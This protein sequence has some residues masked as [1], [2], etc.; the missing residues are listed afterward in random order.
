M[1]PCSCVEAQRKAAGAPA[2]A[3]ALASPG[4]AAKPGP[5]EAA[6]DG[7]P[8]GAN[9]T[10]SARSAADGDSVVVTHARTGGA[11]GDAAPRARRS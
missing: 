5:H 7:E 8:A 3:P 11:P 9:A 10:R 1:S 4:A 6:D 2:P